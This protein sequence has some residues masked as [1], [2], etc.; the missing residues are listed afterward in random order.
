MKANG[1]RKHSCSF[2]LYLV[3]STIWQQNRH[4]RLGGCV[5]WILVKR[6]MSGTYGSNLLYR[7]SKRFVSS[8][9]VV[10]IK[11]IHFCS[12]VANKICLSISALGGNSSF[13]NTYSNFFLGNSRKIYRI[14]QRIRSRSTILIPQSC[15]GVTIYRG[16]HVRIDHIC[17]QSGRMTIHPVIFIV[18]LFFRL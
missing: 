13:L 16:I 18:L 17:T 9:C 5:C 3:G 10:E 1:S 7:E 14:R 6:F 11:C 4:G 12:K 8:R 2:V 15:G